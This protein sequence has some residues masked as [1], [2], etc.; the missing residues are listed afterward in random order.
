MKMFKIIT[1]AAAATL[2][3]FGAYAQD[4][5]SVV[6]KYEKATEL[7]QGKNFAGAIP[8]LEGVISEGLELGDEALEVVSNAQKLLP[9]CYFRVGGGYVQAQDWNSAITNFEKA[10]DLAEL[11]GDVNTG[12][13]AKVWIGRSYTAMGGVAFNNEDYATAAEI[14]AKGYEA[15]PTNTDLAL[16]L[17]KSYGEMGDLEKA[18]GIYNDIMGL[19]HS[20]YAEAVAKAKKDMEYYQTIDI[21]NALEAKDYAKANEL[22]DGILAT[23]P[24]NAT[25][26]MMLIQAANNQSNWA[27]IIANGEKAAS[28]QSDEEMKSTVHFFL[29]V[30]Y[31][32]TDNKAKAIENYRKVT[33]GPRVDTA[34]AQIAALSK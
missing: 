2:L 33:A 1:A 16:N 18:F 17:A 15:D 26:N 3:S 4:Y 11:Y 32:N 12:K 31:Q 22:I 7:V 19:T 23:D 29:G 5:N 13:N 21:S 6:E 10:A 24:D 8:A 30:A 20:K 34:K 28:L 27:K 9:T 14:F 25:V